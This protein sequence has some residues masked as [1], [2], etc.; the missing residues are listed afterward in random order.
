MKSLWGRKVSA[1]GFGEILHK[2]E[3]IAEKK[4]KDLLFIDP[5]FPSSKTCSECVVINKCLELVDSQW[6]C[7]SCQM[8]HNRD[9]NPA[10]NIVRVGASTLSGEVESP[11]VVG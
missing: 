5:W 10:I 3:Y 4:G 9:R 11:V 8:R 7:P 6:Q 2:L 1:L